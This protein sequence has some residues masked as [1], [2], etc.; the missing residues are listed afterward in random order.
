M[1]TTTTTTAPMTSDWMDVPPTYSTQASAEKQRMDFIYH[2]DSLAGQDGYRMIARKHN[3]TDGSVK[4]A[5]KRMKKLVALHGPL[6][7]CTVAHCG[8]LTKC[9]TYCSK[10]LRECYSL[11]V[12]TSNIL[13]AGLGLFAIHYNETPRPA[14]NYV[15]GLNKKPKKSP[16]FEK[17]AHII[18]YT[19]HNLTPTEHKVMKDEL[20]QVGKQPEYTLEIPSAKD[21]PSVYVDAS[22]MLLSSV[23]RFINC[24]TPGPRG[25]AGQPAANVQFMTTGM[26]RAICNIHDGDELIVNYGEKY[27]VSPSTSTLPS[28]IQSPRATEECLG[29][30]MIGSVADTVDMEKEEMSMYESSTSTTTTSSD[31]DQKRSE[32]ESN[33]FI[34]RPIYLNTIC[35]SADTRS[36]SA[37]VKTDEVPVD[38]ASLRGVIG[39][40]GD[41]GY[42]GTTVMAHYI[43]A[44]MYHCYIRPAQIT[45]ANKPQLPIIIHDPTT[46]V[47]LLDPTIHSAT[48]SYGVEPQS[49]LHVDTL[50]TDIPTSLSKYMR[51][52]ELD[53]LC[54]NKLHHWPTKNNGLNC[55]PATLYTIELLSMH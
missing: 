20:K 11:E 4:V 35:L 44:L 3:V 22:D 48:V 53:V 50:A 28:P 16:V 52:D 13:H 33:S 34:F 26:V 32:E 46:C 39:T 1:T 2:S 8:T 6:N 5:I 19:G 38:L 23:S 9:W 41:S 51:L 17:G 49:Y 12:K 24:P 47:R 40:G 29:V 27:V 36:S 37:I 21:R 15:G 31:S 10:H 55:G 25:G 43:Q 30:P 7:I 42:I 14:N 45:I 54:S 18:M